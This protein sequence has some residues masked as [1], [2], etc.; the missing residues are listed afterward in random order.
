LGLGTLSIPGG[1]QGIVEILGSADKDAFVPAR[2]L[3]ASAGGLLLL[4]YG[5]ALYRYFRE[6]SHGV[7]DSGYEEGS[8]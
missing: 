2:I 3:S 7:S 1:A 6:R 8:K 5:T 4:G